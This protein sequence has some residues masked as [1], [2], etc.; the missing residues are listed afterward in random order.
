MRRFRS[1]PGVPAVAL[2]AFPAERTS[3]P[4]FPF[5]SSFAVSFA[6]HRGPGGEREGGGD[7]QRVGLAA[8]LGAPAALGAAAVHRVAADEGEGQPAAVRVV[9]EVGGQLVL[10][11]K[12]Q[13][14]GKAGGQ[15]L[16]WV[17]AR[18]AADRP[19]TGRTSALH[20]GP[21]CNRW[22]SYLGGPPVVAADQVF[23]GPPWKAV[24]DPVRVS[25]REPGPK[26]C[27]DPVC[28]ELNTDAQAVNRPPLFC[29]ARMHVLLFMRRPDS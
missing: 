19:W 3:Q 15:G 7:P 17:L 6:G 10:D 29:A 8:L 2:G 14:E 4:F 28:G 9:E 11:A 25:M 18:R 23:Q 13:A 26:A 21:G 27:P 22:L 12:P 16:H 5:S 20:L 1:R 24:A